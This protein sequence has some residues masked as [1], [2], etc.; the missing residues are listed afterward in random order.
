MLLVL[1]GQQKSASTYL[2]RLARAACTVAGSDQIALRNRLMTGAWARNR[3]FWRDGLAKVGQLADQL[4]TDNALS[5]KTHARY[6]P[7]YGTV[8]DRPDI[9]VLISY[10]HPGDAALSAWEAGVQARA[11]GDPSKPFFAALESPRAA[12][13]WMARVVEKDTTPWLKSGLG[14]AFS[15]DVLTRDPARVLAVLAAP[16]GLSVARLAADPEIAGLIAG[17]A[18]VYNFNQGVAGRHREAFGAADLAYLE[19]RCG[20]FIRFCQGELPLTAL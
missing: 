18:R 8:L 2:A 5:I 7:L 3:G 6:R 20:R 15:Y 16:L 11:A 14:T 10:R 19:E 4:G 1:Y 12:I 9:R 17:R 13:D